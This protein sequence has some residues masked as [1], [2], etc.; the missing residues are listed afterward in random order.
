MMQ[1]VIEDLKFESSDDTTIHLSLNEHGRQRAR[2]LL[3]QKEKI[4]KFISKVGGRKYR[5]ILD[6]SA[7]SVVAESKVTATQTEE[8]QNLPFV[9]KAMELFDAV[10]VEVTEEESSEA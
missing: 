1:A 9:K 10:V 2:F 5:V 7:G 3:T 6:V 4:E 8:A